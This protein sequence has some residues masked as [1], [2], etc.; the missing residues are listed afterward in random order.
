[1]RGILADND[2]QG[3]VKA[4]VSIWLSDTWR[5][6]WNDLDLS[7]LSFSG[8][9]LSRD[10]SDAVVWRACQ[11]EKLVLIAGNRNAERHDSLES[12]IRAE[13]QPDSL[14]VVTLANLERLARDRLY[15]ERVAE[16]LLEKLIAMDDFRGAGRIYV[17]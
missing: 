10:S 16:R 3:F 6:L 2:V 1:M 5:D 13:N 7:V 15:V 17:P 8:L 9:G 4:I 14:P 12:V 11:R